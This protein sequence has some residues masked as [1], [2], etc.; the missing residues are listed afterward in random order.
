MITKAV[1][2]AVLDT[3][4]WLLGLL[5]ESDIEWPTGEAIA[6]WIGPQFGPLDSVVPLSEFFGIAWYTLTAV[7]PV[8]LIIKTTVWLWFMLPIIK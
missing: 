7:V 8:L 1:L 6:E 5:P 4:S 3:L 2:T